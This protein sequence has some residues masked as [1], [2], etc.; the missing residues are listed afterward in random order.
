MFAYAEETGNSG[1]NVFDEDEYFRLGAILTVDDIAPAVDAVFSL[2]L[3]E[4]SIDS[5]HPHDWSEEEVAKLGHQVLDTIEGV[6]PWAFSFTE[7]H[8]PYMATTK[9][10]DVIFDAEENEGVPDFWYFEEIYRHILCI[11]I[12]QAL[13]LPAAKQFW[14]SYPLD[15]M[16]GIIKSLDLVAEDLKATGSTRAVHKVIF[17]AFEFARMNPD[18]FTLTHKAKR[19]GY[20]ERTPNAVAFALLFQAAHDFAAKVASR[21]ERT[22][23]NNQD[24]FRTAHAG[25]DANCGQ[26]SRREAR[27]GGFPEAERH[28]DV[29][30]IKMPSLRTNPGLQAAGLLLWTTQRKPETKALEV[31]R[32][33]VA[34][35]TLDYFIS[36]RMSENIVHMHLSRHERERTG[37][38]RSLH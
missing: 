7:I 33:R 35:Q 17:Q 31:L 18:K 8:K 29:A 22:M 9:L 21:R 5:F 6:G 32:D 28:Y 38:D 10:V 24:E 4:K 23:Q 25:T 30:K 11:T 1:P 12:D 2:F 34:A 13:S 27:D 14:E 15:D 36:R 20:D 37:K 19:K 16:D 26:T 3:A